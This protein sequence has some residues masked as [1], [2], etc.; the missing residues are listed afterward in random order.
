MEICDDSTTNDD[1]LTTQLDLS[2]NVT[3]L[4]QAERMNAK[5]RKSME[6]AHKIIP[7]FMNDVNI[8]YA[9]VFD[10][11]GGRG[12]VDWVVSHLDNNLREAIESN[13]L[14]S[15]E[16]CLEYAFL[17]TDIQTKQKELCVDGSTAAIVFIQ[18]QL[19]G[20]R[21]L[22][23]ANVGD[24]RTLI[25]N[26]GQ[27]IRLSYDHKAIDENEIRR[28]NASGG[29]VSKG[30]VGGLL[31]IT[32]SFG[33]HSLKNYVTAHPYI[34]KYE[35]TDQDQFL[36]IAC[37]GIFDVMTDQEVIDF[38]QTHQGESGFDPANSLADEAI[39][40]DTNDNITVLVIGL[41]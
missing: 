12:V 34:T 14:T 19:D 3:Y 17:Y 16:Q 32:R 40:R 28:I 23:C 37:D 27:A 11:H 10:G 33:D 22:Y 4:F 36:V 21:I 8:F 13:E 15:I 30:R 25:C 7:C 38:I 9:G 31:A 24:T 18:K 1:K 39:K 35:I 6:D 20:K 2:K 41:Q 5:R 29:F 26:N